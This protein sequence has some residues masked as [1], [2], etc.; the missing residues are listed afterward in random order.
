[1]DEKRKGEIAWEL[2][3]R[4]VKKRM[5]IGEISNIKRD[6]GNISQETGIPLTELSEF[7]KILITEVCGEE[8]SSLRKK[9]R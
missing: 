5:H 4:D 3:K 9:L 7:A 2:T 6:L 1:M 8:I